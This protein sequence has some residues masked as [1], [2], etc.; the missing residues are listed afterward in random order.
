MTARLELFGSAGCPFTAELREQLEWDGRDFD[1]HDVE[2]DAAAFARMVALTGG[3][4]SVPVL[5]EDGR[6]VQVGWQGRSCLAAPPA[7]GAAGGENAAT[8][9]AGAATASGGDLAGQESSAPDSR[10]PPAPA[11]GA[12]PAG[13]PGAGGGRNGHV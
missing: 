7:G 1:D 3:R 6:V 4:T 10:N 11:A 9:P 2:T 8:G 13:E 12:P 5:V